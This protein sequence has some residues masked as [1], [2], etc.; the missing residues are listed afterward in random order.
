[1]FTGRKKGKSEMVL[2]VLDSLQ[3]GFIGFIFV[4]AGTSRKKG[5][6][7]LVL[8]VLDSFAN[9]TYWNFPFFRPVPAGKKEDPNWSCLY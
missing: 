6:S 3:T 9:R 5:K 1:M 8:F 7:E 2:F 4:P